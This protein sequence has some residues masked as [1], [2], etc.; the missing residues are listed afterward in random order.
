[1]NELQENWND[2]I[3][4]ANL[5]SR[6]GSGDVADYLR[7]RDANDAA[8]RLGIEWLLGAFLEVAAEANRRGFGIAVERKEEHSFTVGT[9]TMQ[10]SLVRLKRGIRSVS[11]EAG[12]PRSPQDGFV[13]GGGLARARIS[14][15]G[16]PK[17]NE[18]LMLI[19]S[20]QSAPVWFVVAE[21]DF[22]HPFQIPRLQHH[23]ETFVGNS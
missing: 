17:A 11:I 9:A 23:F 7:L 14:H 13:R 1:M 10:G 4:E 18:D 2:F 22:R 20:E 12:S 5:R 3:R 21:T 19:H 15:F 8:R 6:G 16:Q